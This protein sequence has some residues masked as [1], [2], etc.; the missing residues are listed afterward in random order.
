MKLLYVCL[1]PIQQGEAPYAH[2]HEIVKGLRARGW[3]VDLVAPERTEHRNAFDRIRSWTT[4]LLVV[5]RKLRG[6]D[7]CYV[8][9]HMIAAPVA[10]AARLLRVPQVHEL[11]GTWREAALVRPWMARLAPLVRFAYGHQYALADGAI[12]V[13]PQLEDWGRRAGARRVTVVGNGADTERFRPDLPRPA[14][15]P[16]APYVLFFGAFTRW[17]GIDTLL[18]AHADP[19]WPK[20]VHLVLAGDGTVADDVRRRSAGNPTMHWIGVVPYDEI[21]AWAAN[22]ACV[23]ILKKASVADA[24]FAPIKLYES[25]AAGAAIVATDTPGL[26]ETVRKYDCGVVVPVDDAHAAALG[27]AELTSDPA[28][29]K[30]MG[31]RGRAAAVAEFSWDRRAAETDEFLRVVVAD[32]RR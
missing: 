8:R 22:A 30:A 4:V 10:W 32:R 14:N 5:L 9:S 13:T 24:G 15:A 16:D 17:Q 18:D 29:V 3:D 21:P 23:A 7:A 20:D 6:A 1:Q 12:G 26:A 25:M 28:R 11:N 19:A 2:V 27:V 31:E